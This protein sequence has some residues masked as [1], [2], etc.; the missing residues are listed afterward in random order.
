MSSYGIPKQRSGNARNICRSR[1]AQTRLAA[2]DRGNW[3]RHRHRRF[4]HVLL[5]YTA[6][7][8]G[9]GRAGIHNAKVTITALSASQIRLTDLRL[10]DAIEIKTMNAAFDLSHLPGNPVTRVT[11]D[12]V[13]ADLAGVRR[14]LAKMSPDRTEPDGA[15]TAPPPTIRSLLTQM[16]E[17]PDITVRNISLKY[18]D[19]NGLVTAIGSIHA[20]RT[21][22]GAY[23]IRV[24]MELSGNIDGTTHA[25]VIDGTTNL[26]AESATIDIRAKTNE[27][28]LA[29]AIEAR[30]DLSSDPAIFK[31]TTRL[32]T[33]DFATLAALMPGLEAAGGSLKIK[34]ETLSPLAFGLDTPLGLPAVA[35]ALRKSGND[36]IR[37][38]AVLAD[39]SYGERVTGS[40]RKPVL[41]RR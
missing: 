18:G 14:E 26:A 30:A 15:D 11:V 12:G 33:D 25:I 22:I 39:A 2:V 20:A 3:R 37:F 19:A 31:A 7:E 8:F 1:N 4:S 10:G 38:E 28:A 13:R 9:L 6:G 24:G 41:P 21:N 27:G 40:E 29:G 17:L 35:A 32:E 5:A 16:A 23:D 34:A 36:G